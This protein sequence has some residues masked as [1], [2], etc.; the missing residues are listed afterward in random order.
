MAHNLISAYEMLNK[1]RV[2]VYVFSP[3]TWVYPGVVEYIQ[4]SLTM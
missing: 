1:M 2:L 4:V 3:K